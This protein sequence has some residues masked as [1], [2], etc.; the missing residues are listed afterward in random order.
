MKQS[1][2][3]RKKNVDVVDLTQDSDSDDVGHHSPQLSGG[4]AISRVAMHSR[5]PST[6]GLLGA[7]WTR[8]D[9]LAHHVLAKTPSVGLTEK[10]AQKSVAPTA[11]TNGSVLAS[12]PNQQARLDHWLHAAALKPPMDSATPMQ[13]SHSQD[14]ENARS[15]GRKRKPNLR[16]I[17]ETLN[18]LS[19]AS[20]ALPGLPNGASEVLERANQSSNDSNARRISEIHSRILSARRQGSPTPMRSGPPR[21]PMRL[22]NGGRLKRG[23]TAEP[24]CLSG[25]RG[26]V[27]L[28]RP[29]KR[30]LSPTEMTA[31]L[32]KYL[33]EIA[34]GNTYFVTGMLLNDHMRSGRST[35]KCGRYYC[36]PTEH[37]EAES[38]IKDMRAIQFPSMPKGLY[39]GAK[40]GKL[41]AV[42]WKNHNSKAIEGRMT[43]PL[44]KHTSAIIPVPKYNSYTSLRRN[45][46]AED[47]DKL[48][49]FPY[50]G[51]D[52]NDEGALQEL[53]SDWTKKLPTVHQ[54]TELAATLADTADKFMDETGLS[55]YDAL[56]YL[57]GNIEVVSPQAI[58]R[59]E[60]EEARRER[61]VAALYQDFELE[62]AKQ[63]L[64]LDSIPPLTPAGLAIAPAVCK[65]WKDITTISLWDVIKNGKGEYSEKQGQK[66]PKISDQDEASAYY[67]VG[68]VHSL[69]CLACFTHECPAHHHVFGY[70]GVDNEENPIH[71]LIDNSTNPFRNDEA[72]SNLC[73]LK[74]EVS[75][76]PA[77]KPWSIDQLALLK[78][79]LKIW[80]NFER[81]GCLMAL[82][83]DRPCAEIHM[84]ISSEK[85]SSLEA[86]PMGIP[87]TSSVDSGT[88]PPK[89]TV[90]GEKRKRPVKLLDR[91]DIGNTSLHAERTNFEPCNHTGSCNERRCDCVENE[92]VCEKTCRCPP[93]CP[94]RWRGCS[95]S[96][97][98]AKV[99]SSDK[100][101]CLKMSREC[102]PDL[103]G[104]CGAIEILDPVNRH[105]DELCLRK[106]ANVSLQRDRPKRTL[107]GAS[108][109][110]GYGLF[111]GEPTK[112][113][114]FLGEYKGELISN[115]E[116]ER[117]G[118]VYDVR[119]FSYLF[120]VNEDHVIDANRGGNKFRFVNHSKLGE[121][122][123]P[124]VVFANG[125]HRIGMYAKRDLV[126]G[127]ELYFNYNYGGKS[128]KFVQKEI[129]APSAPQTV[130]PRSN[131]TGG[132]S[133]RPGGSKKNGKKGGPRPGAGRKPSSN[134]PPSEDVEGSDTGG[135][136]N[137]ASDV[138]EFDTNGGKSDPN[139]TSL[140]D[141]YAEFH[142]MILPRGP[143]ARTIQQPSLAGR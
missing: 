85:A 92:V 74:G 18:G 137:T 129:D 78:S 16:Y 12:T 45:V 88:Q 62:P 47:D 35:I 58:S 143:P 23:L 21:T 97:G 132:G 50:F 139:V 59:E 9:R 42:I 133:G 98:G 101:E 95:C 60:K 120:N 108:K 123:Y 99:C 89:E 76:D 22:S 66:P 125:V 72:C 39:D 104:T 5:R 131:K 34:E 96:K 20:R 56:H 100:C 124:R 115:D 29:T 116:A 93:E 41:N 110:A 52:I 121:N 27:D 136:R 135:G 15:S 2:E 55:Y 113:G 114:E 71:P 86:A 103:C 118:V 102:D 90:T 64:Y 117:R 73:F 48:K 51:D 130:R 65:I 75:L 43:V 19:P 63:K 87:E 28:H 106:C 53:Y 68:T 1:Q 94:R 3:P 128:L 8:E 44:T 11:L 38:P 127:E 54:R 109:L 81:A 138:Y 126:A 70:L 134:K 112:A 31:L 4:H 141:A 122:C 30:V 7:A 57:I 82:V 91:D 142:S 49:Y 13:L 61:K 83:I 140:D 33:A 24:G 32:E 107:V 40:Y 77:R 14:S 119:G 46:L 84:M 67:S 80:G 36:A 105:N 6:V 111:M 17:R 79:S 26:Q 10:V 69:K 37:T 25:L